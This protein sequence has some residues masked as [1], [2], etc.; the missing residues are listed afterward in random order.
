MDSVDFGREY[1][2]GMDLYDA[3]VV[4]GFNK[5]FLGIEDTNTKAVVIDAKGLTAEQVYNR[6]ENSLQ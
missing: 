3:V 4:T 6:L 2:K 1:T 5:D